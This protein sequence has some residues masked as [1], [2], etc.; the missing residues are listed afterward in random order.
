MEQNT[1]PQPRVSSGE[2][3]SLLYQSYL[4]VVAGLLRKTVSHLTG[5]ELPRQKKITINT[6][7][8][9]GGSVTISVWTPIGNL[10]SGKPLPLVLV[11]EGGGFVLGEPKDGQHNSSRI[12]DEVL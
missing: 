1:I 3:Y 6:P 2:G 12:S 8:F 4:H 5:P 7:S 10:D 9:G 11:L